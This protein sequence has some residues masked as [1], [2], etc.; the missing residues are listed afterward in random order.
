MI[1]LNIQLD[2]ESHE[3]VERYKTRAHLLQYTTPD[4]LHDET[5]NKY[6]R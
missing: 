4:L 2:N 3:L 5:E 6:Y 1:C